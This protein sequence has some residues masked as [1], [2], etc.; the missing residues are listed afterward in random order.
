[1]KPEPLQRL[2]SLVIAITFL[3][4]TLHSETYYVTVDDSGFSPSALNINV[5]DT[6]V[7]VNGDEDDFPH[8]ATSNLSVAHPDYWRVFLTSFEET[9]QNTFDNPG[10][11]TYRDEFTSITGTITASMV[12][13][14][15]I[16]LAAPRLEAGQFLFDATGLT[17]GKTNVLEISTNFMHWTAIQT[18][19]ADAASMT[20]TNTVGPGANLFRLLQQQ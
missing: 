16:T 2:A 6:V 17:I 18:N 3:T 20:F 5:G 9:G 1:M 19:I 4:A 8:T 7:W 11:F 15:A 12:A 14:P 10:T 13:T